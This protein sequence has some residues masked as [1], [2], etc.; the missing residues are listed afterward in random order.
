[1][2]VGEPGKAGFDLLTGEWAGNDLLNPVTVGASSEQGGCGPFAAIGH[3]FDH[4]LNVRAGFV[5]TGSHGF[6]GGNGCKRTFEG[7]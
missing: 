7:V 5:Q 3:G 1:M 4:N 2:G 6:T